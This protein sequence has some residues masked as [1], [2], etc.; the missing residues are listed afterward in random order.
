MNLYHGSGYKQTELKPGFKHSGE[1]V[2]W[3]KY[4]SNDY[5]YVSSHRNTAILLGIASALEKKFDLEHTNID[6]AK[7]VV[8]L[9][10]RDKP[11]SSDA[12]YD[13]DVWV[14]TIGYNDADEWVHNRNPF[15]NIK[16]EY[17]TKNT[18]TSDRI[19]EIAK[20]DVAKVLNGFAIHITGPQS[21]S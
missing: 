8:R 3:D 2:N 20:V 15:N 9:K 1:L 12:L 4:E 21:G 17:K 16:T 10:F 5:L 6:E 14:Y 11:P 7:R 13:I 18:I 19:I